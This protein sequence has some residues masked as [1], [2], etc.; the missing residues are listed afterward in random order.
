MKKL[1]GEEPRK[2]VPIS[3]RHIKPGVKTQTIADGYSLYLV[4]M[5]GGAMYWRYKY[6]FGGKRKQLALGSVAVWR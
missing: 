6:R 1:N 4:V 2:I 5:P 3:L